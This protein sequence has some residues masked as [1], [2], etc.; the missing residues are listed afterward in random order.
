MPVVTESG[1][2]SPRNMRRRGVRTWNTLSIVL[3]LLML[4]GIYSAMVRAPYPV[5]RLPDGA[6]VGLVG[7]TFKN[8][9][10]VAVG[11]AWER[12]LS[13]WRTS[14]PTSAWRVSL[15][16]GK[17][18][19]VWLH[20]SRSYFWRNP[21]APAEVLRSPAGDEWLAESGSADSVESPVGELEGHSFPIFPRRHRLL[22]LRVYQKTGG[23]GPGPQGWVNFSFLNPAYRD[24][25]IWTPESFPIVRR[26]GDLKVELTS[27]RTGVD[28]PAGSARAPISYLAA[29]FATFA[30]P[31]T[32][33]PI[34]NG[35]RL[36]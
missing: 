36:S 31:A 14:G 4:A 9:K 16:V 22:T 1:K 6:S 5:H 10:T 23:W 7:V 3:A 25:P 27:L 34:P 2:M 33:L 19:T 13:T 21:D 12:L 8:S 29:T 26:S 30:L 11:S 32:G 18:T 28:F 15:P 17:S 24:Y 35:S 20:Y